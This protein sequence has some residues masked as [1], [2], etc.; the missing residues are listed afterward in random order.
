MREVIKKLPETE[1]DVSMTGEVF[2]DFFP[3]GV[4]LSLKLSIKPEEGL[5]EFDYTDMPD[6]KAFGYNL[7][8]ATAR[9]SEHC[10]V[11]YPF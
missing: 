11:P 10:K 9:C 8:Y 1:V 2:D 3:N 6:Q 7:T 5:I 4:P